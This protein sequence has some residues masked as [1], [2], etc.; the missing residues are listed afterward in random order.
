[1]G[2][3]SDASDFYNYRKNHGPPTR[4]VVDQLPEAV[5]KVFLEQLD[6]DHVVLDELIQD[7]VGLL[8]HLRQQRVGLGEAAGDQ[9]GRP[10]R[11][12]AVRA[13]Q[14]RDDDQDAVLGE[15]SPVA[16]SY[17]AHVSHAE[18]VDEGDAGLNVVD[19]SRAGRRQLDDCAVL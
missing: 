5:V 3:A 17:V 12:A 14:R 19:N 2:I 18:A 11:G 16:Q 1:D 15:M 10:G 4:T 8:A 7:A 6:L 9:L 13:A